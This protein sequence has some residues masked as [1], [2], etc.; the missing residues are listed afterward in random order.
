MS[1]PADS[2]SQ[3]TGVL[4]RALRYGLGGTIAL[5]VLLAPGMASA[6]KKST[7][8]SDYSYDRNVR[9]KMETCDRESDSQKVHSDVRFSTDPG[10][11]VGKYVTDGDGSNGNCASRSMSVVSGGPRL[12][13]HR[14]VE[15]RLL[16]DITG[17]W[18]S[19]T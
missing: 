2:S 3:A 1:T 6:D 4:P 18:V 15:Q 10:Y 5:A 8:G 9:T 19:T 11:T 13:Q 16:G 14:T 17:N 7:E 12:A